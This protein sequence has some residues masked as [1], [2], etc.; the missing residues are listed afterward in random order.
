MTTAF[1]R[2]D[3]TAQIRLELVGHERG[4]TTGLDLGLR[5]I[6]VW[7]VGQTRSP[8]TTPHRRDQPSGILQHRLDPRVDPARARRRRSQDDRP[9]DRAFE[10]RAELDPTEHHGE[11]RPSSCRECRTPL[12]VDAPPFDGFERCYE[13]C[14]WSPSS[15]NSQTTR[16]AGVVHPS[17][18]G[19]GVRFDFFAETHSRFYAPV[20]LGIWCADWETGCEALAIPGRFAVLTP[21]ERGVPEPGVALPHYDVSW[22]ARAGPSPQSTQAQA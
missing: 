18:T 15:F 21:A 12:D 11:H 2:P 10:H 4:Q 9:R 22:I 5:W 1:A 19:Q 3:A 17:P 6:A 14:Q 13:A 20:A 8:F 16:C 7:R